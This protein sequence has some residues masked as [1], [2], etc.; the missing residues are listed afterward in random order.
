MSVFIIAEAGVNHNGKIDLALR[1]CDKAR[2][3]GVDAIKFQTWITENI[4]TQVADLASYQEKN[5]TSKSDTQ[6]QMLKKLELS[7]ND[8]I[9]I[10]KYCSK[11]GINFLSTPDDE[12]SLNFLVGLK[13][14]FIKVSSGDVTNIPYLRKIGSTKQHVVLSTGMSTL[15]DVDLAYNTLITSGSPKVTLLHCTTNYP[16]PMN[17]VNLKAMLT[18]KEVFKCDVGYS[19][20]T[21]GIEIPIAAVAMGARIIEKHF[22]LERTMEGPD[23]LASLNPKELKEMVQAIRNIEIAL[24]SGIKE[25]NVSEKE[26]SKVVLKSI[27]AK[28]N[29]TKGELFSEE[30]ITIK[31]SNGGISAQKWDLVIGKKSL[32]NFV[33][34]QLISLE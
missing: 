25:P 4:V 16:C 2:E 1:L 27:V 22:T 7:F 15:A 23:H 3:A 33:P 10:K 32:Y 34:D 26:I 20:H 19:D 11:I 28:K 5:I 14:K 6:F 9:E 12:V 21:L 18:L 30:N 31:R 24:G 8:F 29:I 13:M 17:E